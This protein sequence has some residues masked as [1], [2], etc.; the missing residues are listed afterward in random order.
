VIRSP[1]P[2]VAPALLPAATRAPAPAAACLLAL[3]LGSIAAGARAAVLP[4]EGAQ[5]AVVAAAVSAAS[6]PAALPGPLADRPRVLE[7][8]FEGADPVDGLRSFVPIED[9]A[10]LDARDV[11]DAV[12]ALHASARFSRVA[13]F[14]EAVPAEQVPQ[15]WP[16]AVRVVFVLTPV[17]R[18]AEVAFPGHEAL[19]ASILHQ[20]ANLQVNAEFQPEA[21]PRAIEAIR[22]AY[23]R[24]GYRHVAIAPVQNEIDGAVRLDLRIAEGSATRVGRVVFSGDLGLGEEELAA[25][26]KLA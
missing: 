1:P 20:T 22:A 15:G 13:A 3:A 4:P 16:G 11:R 24:I 6:R 18:L 25:S 8:R 10:P 19:A 26:F 14:A 17:L 23:F 9:G 2:A 21:V 5:P 7:V 12:R